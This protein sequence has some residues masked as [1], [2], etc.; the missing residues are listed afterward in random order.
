GEPGLQPGPEDQGVAVLA[1]RPPDPDPEADRPAA[2]AERSAAEAADAHGHADVA[3][4]LAELAGEQVY[5]AVGRGVEALEPPGGDPP[6]AGDPGGSR[7]PRRRPRP[8]R[9]GGE[10]ERRGDG[11]MQEGAAVDVL[12]HGRGTS[13]GD[14]PGWTAPLGASRPRLGPG[15]RGGGVSPPE[16]E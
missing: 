16:G 12:G 4:P 8:P 2:R 3:R 6:V 10:A 5:V 15:L 9:G 7:R 13:A 14:L 1:E 11:V